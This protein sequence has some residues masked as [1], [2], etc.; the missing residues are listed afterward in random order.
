VHLMSMSCGH[1]RAIREGAG[2]ERR[3]IP[4]APWHT[5]EFTVWPRAVSRPRGAKETPQPEDCG[6]RSSIG[7]NST[8]RP[9]LARPQTGPVGAKEFS[10]I[11]RRLQAGVGRRRHPLGPRSRCCPACLGEGR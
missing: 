9:V 5:T 6:A 10:A 11:G 3:R 8:L 4:V 1:Q 7:G 2:R